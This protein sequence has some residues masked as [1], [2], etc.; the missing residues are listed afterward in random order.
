MTKSLNE[1]RYVEYLTA[2]QAAQVL[3]VPYKLVKKAFDRRDIPVKYFDSLIPKAKAEDV[4]AWADAAPDVP[5]GQW[6]V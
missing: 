1:L 4:R 2:P 6:R 5:G 3:N